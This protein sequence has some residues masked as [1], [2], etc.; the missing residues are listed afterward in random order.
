MIYYADIL[1][2]KTIDMDMPVHHSE[3][4]LWECGK[5]RDMTSIMLCSTSPLKI[6]AAEVPGSWWRCQQ[7]ALP[8]TL[9]SGGQ[10]KTLMASYGILW[11]LMAMSFP[12][13]RWLWYSSTRPAYTCQLPHLHQDDSCSRRLIQRYPRYYDK[14]GQ[15]QRIPI[16]QRFVDMHLSLDL[17]NG[18]CQ[19][20]L[21]HIL[22]IPTQRLFSTFTSFRPVAPIPRRKRVW[23]FWVS[24]CL[25]KDRLDFVTHSLII[26]SPFFAPSIYIIE[27]YKPRSHQSTLWQ[28]MGRCLSPG[29]SGV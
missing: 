13:I 16:S 15:Q 29:I 20:W 11:H 17:V 27:G 9:P 8:G 23:C 14:V 6:L 5:S 26:P 12:W 19:S 4:R 28:K 22:R 3:D 10:T 21:C 2:G 1:T 24:K 7:L 18:F 25:H